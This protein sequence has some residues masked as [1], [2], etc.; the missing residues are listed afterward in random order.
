MRHFVPLLAVAA[1]GALIAFA[2]ASQA[3]VSAP[4]ETAAGSAAANTEPARGVT[5][6]ET[7]RRET[8]TADALADGAPAKSPAGIGTLFLPSSERARIAGAV[9]DHEPM[10]RGTTVRLALE[11]EMAPGMHV[12]ANP[13]SED[14]LIPVQANI[15]GADG[16]NVLEAFYPEAESRK[17]P[18]ADEPFNVYEGNFVIG[19]LLAVAED[20]PA[21]GRQ[22]EIVLE[23]QAC[24][25]EACFAPATTSARLPVMVVADADDAAAVSSPLLNR[26]PFPR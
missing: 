20:I 18:Y 13:P 8:T 2:I 12:N 17:F 10:A 9:V 11:V 16:F 3:P 19:L 21:G 24:N 26:A 22:L 25:D 7:A 5:E 4:Q 15:T 6:S 23:Y 14:W 1:I